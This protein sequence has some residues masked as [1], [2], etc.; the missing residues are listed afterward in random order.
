MVVPDKHLVRANGLNGALGGII[1]IAGPSAGAFLMAAFPMQWV[2][3][4][5]YIST[6]IFVGCLLP[7]RIPQPP[8]TTLTTNFNVIGDMLQGFRYV[9]SWRGLLILLVL[10]SMINFFLGPVNVLR[11]LFVTSYLGGDVLKLGWLQA[12]FG[13]GV[14][15]GGLI[16]NVWSGFKRRI[17]TTFSGLLILSISV[18]LFGFITESLFF[19]GLALMLFAGLGCTFCNTPIWAILQKTVAKDIQGRVFTLVGSVSGAMMI[20]VLA[21][22]GPVVNAI[23]V[24]EVY[25]IAGS[26]MIVLTMV[27]FTSRDLMN[28]ENQKAAEQP[29][30]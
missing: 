12:A 5:D 29:L 27:S 11:P 19:G 17:F 23:G 20:P 10:C 1:N 18:I 25:I 26:A 6:I 4:I 2:L 3:S 24:R 13:A 21:I 8:R 9:I 15:A 16:F 30:E 14:I 22:A 28:Y 7:L